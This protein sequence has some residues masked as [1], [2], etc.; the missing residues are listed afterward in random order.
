M[1]RLAL[2]TIREEL[3]AMGGQIDVDPGEAMLVMVK[4]AAFNVAFLRAKVEQLQQGW[5]DNATGIVGYE[6]HGKAG[7]AQREHILVEMYDKERD[8]LVRYA[9]MCRDAG[10][11]ERRIQVMEEQGRWLTRTLDLVLERLELSDDQL[12]AL[13]L[14]MRG[15][16][17]QLEVEPGASH[18][19]E[20]EALDDDDDDDD[21]LPA[22]QPPWMFGQEDEA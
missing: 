8:R 5:G 13:P 10:I 14:I 6:D 18:V 15:V 2:A 22:P 20:D 11:E 4:E 1:R 9:K 17:A 12:A 16:I 19:E 3:S 7:L 21:V